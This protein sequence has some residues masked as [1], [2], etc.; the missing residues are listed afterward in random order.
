MSDV[1][2]NLCHVICVIDTFII[3]D[4]IDDQSLNE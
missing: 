1:G 4:I 2:I 3:D